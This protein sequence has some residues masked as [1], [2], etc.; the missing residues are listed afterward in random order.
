MVEDNPFFHQYGSHSQNDDDEAIM[1]ETIKEAQQDP[2]F[3]KFMKKVLEMDKE[4]YLL[5]LASQGAKFPHGFDDLRLRQIEWISETR[6]DTIETHNERNQNNWDNEVG[7]N[8]DNPL[9][10]LTQQIQALQT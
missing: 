7:N 5:M 3:G 2:K 10:A 1:K 4:K 8:V 9:L 6:N